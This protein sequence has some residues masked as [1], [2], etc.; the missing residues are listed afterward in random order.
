M[1]DR[2]FKSGALAVEHR[3]EMPESIRVDVTPS[4]H[5]T[6]MVYPA[7]PR[8]CA[9]ICLILAH[10]AG[11]NQTSAFMVRVA[12]ARAY[13]YFGRELPKRQPRLF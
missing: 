6:A 2:S 1:T 3:A 5:V 4:E 7:P 10:G 9:G 8:D 12:T 13:E 11:A